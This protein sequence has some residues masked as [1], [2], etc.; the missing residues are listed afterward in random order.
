VKEFKSIQLNIVDE[1]I[2]PG[3]HNKLHG[4]LH[5]YWEISCPT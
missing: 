3:G 1:E 5:T 4:I 2:E